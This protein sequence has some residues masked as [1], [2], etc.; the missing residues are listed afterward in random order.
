MKGI[1]IIVCC[2][3]SAKRLPETLD[4]LIN[5]VNSGFDWEIIIVD[6]ASIDDTNKVASDI[7]SSAFPSTKFKIFIEPVAGLSNARRKGYLNSKYDYL[8]FCDDDNWLNENYVQIAFDTLEKSENI[9]ILGGFGEAVFEKKK[10]EWF[11]T[12]QLNFAVGVQSSSLSELSKTETVYGAGFIVRKKIFQ[13]LDSIGFQSLL[14]DRKGTDLMSGGDTEICYVTKYLGYE[15]Y[16][17]NRLRFKHLMPEGR[18]NWQYLKQ[19]HYGFG[20]SRLYLQAYKHMEAMNEIPGANLRYPFWFDKYIHQ[21]KELISLIPNILFKLNE[22]G[23]DNVL[24]YHAMRGELYELR[25]LRSKYRKIFEEILTLKIDITLGK[26][27][28]E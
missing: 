18:M 15:I 13:K 20:R 17:S 8:L 21:L 26:L 1:S 23:N 25:R 24:K 12:Y 9:G 14:S 28:N 4:H 3:N 11:D 7:L 19:L 10:P 16:Y 22:I 27:N 5:Q 6:N 2:Y